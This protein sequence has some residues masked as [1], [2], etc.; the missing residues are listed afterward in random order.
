MKSSAF[1]SD[2]HLMLRM[3]GLESKVFTWKGNLNYWAQFTT[4]FFSKS[5]INQ[6]FTWRTVDS[7]TKMSFDLNLGTLPMCL[8]GAIWPFL[9]GIFHPSKTQR[10]WHPAS[11]TPESMGIEQMVPEHRSLGTVDFLSEISFHTG[12]I[13]LNLIRIFREH[14]I[15]LEFRQIHKTHKWF[16]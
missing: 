5:H 1:P 13:W 11:G 2:L 10:F 9:G 4:F 12:G 15:V 16:A 14:L 6:K 7:S 3:L 8:F